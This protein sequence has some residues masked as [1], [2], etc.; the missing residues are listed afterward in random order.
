MVLFVSFLSQLA[1]I[2]TL[3]VFYNVNDGH[4]YYIF[5][6]LLKKYSNYHILK[7][8]ACILHILSF[9]GFYLAFVTRMNVDWLLNPQNIAFTVH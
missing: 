3:R 7:A 5:N 8:V 1:Q 6:Y 9:K 2:F 4:V